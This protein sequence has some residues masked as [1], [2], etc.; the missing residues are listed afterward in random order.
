LRLVPDESADQP[1]TPRLRA[2]IAAKDEQI[3]VLQAQVEAPFPVLAAYSRAWF[4]GQ[5][6]SIIASLAAI[7]GVVLGAVLTYFFQVRNA[8]QAQEFT[9][10]QQFRQE[11]L[12]AY[13]EFAGIVTDLRRSENDRWHREQEDPQGAPFIS[14]RDESYQLRARATAAMCRVQLAGADATL[15]QLAERALNATTEVHTANDEDD[16]A[17]RGEKARVALQD[18]LAAAASHVR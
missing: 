10:D 3:A 4:A 11:R 5:V 16:R 6:D 7:I 17:R 8:R 14:A 1:L 2:V 13:S 18:F 15:S 12:A 9:R